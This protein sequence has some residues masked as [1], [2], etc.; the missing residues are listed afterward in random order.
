LT[1]YTNKVFISS[2]SE[3]LQEYRAAAYRAA[4]AADCSAVF[5]NRGCTDG[6]GF[7]IIIVDSRAAGDGLQQVST[8]AGERKNEVLSFRVDNGTTPD[9]LQ[10]ALRQALIKW[11][12]RHPCPRGYLESLHADTAWI[13][14]AGSDNHGAR[15]RVA[16]ADL[17][18]PP[19][20]SRVR[21][22]GKSFALAEDFHECNHVLLGDPGCGKTTVLRRV[23]HRL[24]EACLRDDHKW[25]PALIG[26]DCLAEYVARMAA[27]SATDPDWIPWFLAEQSSLW[28]LD[29]AFFRAKLENGG[30]LL[31]LD[32]LDAVPA[33]PLRESLARLIVNAS[34]AWPGCR[35]VVTSRPG[36]YRHESELRDF[37][38]V[39]IQEL[40]DK[41]AVRFIEQWSRIVHP[42]DAAAAK[43]HQDELLFAVLNWPHGLAHNP[44]AL[45]AMAVVHRNDH[46]LPEQRTEL[47]ESILSWRLRSREM[48]AR[49]TPE[50]RLKLLERLAMEPDPGDAAGPADSNKTAKLVAEEFY[51]ADEIEPIRHAEQFLTTEEEASGIVL[52]R[53]HQLVFCH[54][55]IRQYLAA[56]GLA[57]LPK[58]GREEW[59][60][61]K[62]CDPRWREVVLLYAGHLSQ[63][64]P[65]QLHPLFSAILDRQGTDLLQWSHCA[66]TIGA[67]IA[68]LR[69]MGFQPRDQRYRDL[70]GALMTVF[71]TGSELPLKLRIQAAEAIGQAGDPRLHQHNWIRM[72]AGKMVVGEGDDAWEAELDAFEIARYPVTVEEFGKFVEG[73]GRKPANWKKQRLYPNRPVVQVSWHDAAAYCEWAQVRLPTEVEWERAARGPEGRT[74]PWGE[75]EPSPSRANYVDAEIRAHTPVGLFPLGATPE[76]ICDLAGNTWEW[77]LDWHDAYPRTARRNPRGPESGKF[78]VIRGGSCYFDSW[79]LRAAVRGRFVPEFRNCFVGFRVVRNTGQL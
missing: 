53:G 59:L 36:A 56:R 31:L 51:S 66:S 19:L 65:E 32:S 23:V 74:Y 12:E 9:H 39:T 40:P 8:H 4:V 33:R 29:A 63:Q 57:S 37:E 79:Y 61:Q 72:P 58:S 67:M 22:P 11:R 13:E 30:C 71:E 7:L 27:E 60:S 73:G 55:A 38:E 2:A 69:S 16:L 28:N 47:Y 10:A 18:V 70:V 48:L 49:E 34:T 76:G 20:V 24:S 62:L 41:S 44:L 68:E 77:I 45:T 1:A 43:A 17:Y 15:Y 78:K 46:R 6:P 42:E 5:T 14:P 64:Q 54:H 52:T 25:F 21:E 50:A 3:G 35:F 26:L 75:E